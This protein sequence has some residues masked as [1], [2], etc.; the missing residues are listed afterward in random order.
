MIAPTGIK[1][2]VGCSVERFYKNG[3]VAFKAETKKRAVVCDGMSNVCKYNF[4]QCN[5]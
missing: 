2:L 4:H 3:K 5:W 1:K